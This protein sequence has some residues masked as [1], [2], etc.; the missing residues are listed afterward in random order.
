MTNCCAQA[1]T[2]N[3]PTDVMLDMLLRMPLSK[4]VEVTVACQFTD[5]QLYFGKIMGDKIKRM[6]DSLTN[7]TKLATSAQLRVLSTLLKRFGEGKN[8]FTRSSVV[9]TGVTTTIARVSPEGKAVPRFN[10][11]D[12]EGDVGIAFQVLS[13]LIGDGQPRLHFRLEVRLG[14]SDAVFTF[15]KDLVAS[16]ITDSMV[17]CKVA[18]RDDVELASAFLLKFQTSWRSE[19]VLF[20]APVTWLR[21]CA[22]LV[23]ECH[24]PVTWKD[25]TGRA[26]RTY[27]QPG[28]IPA[29]KRRFFNVE[30]WA[31]FFFA[32]TPGSGVVLT[33]PPIPALESYGVWPCAHR[34]VHPGT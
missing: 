23:L 2:G 20:E 33:M 13:T 31:T 12:P 29:E 22:A 26:A 34:S 28:P 17:H 4:L 1:E 8:I 5:D 6:E 27:D 11:S 19:E 3:I 9:A 24:G 14:G 18:N 25:L 10:L 16:K 21:E 30:V 32:S 7:G 15:T